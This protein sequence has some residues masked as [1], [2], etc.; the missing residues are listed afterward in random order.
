M[1][2]TRLLL[3][4]AALLAAGSVMG[5]L[6][7]PHKGERTRRKLMRKAKRFVTAIDGATE[8][9]KEALDLIAGYL[10]DKRKATSAQGA[11]NG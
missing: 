9:G 7:A 2:A 4:C 3:G 5:V 1:K 10:K 6:C 8:S 11:D